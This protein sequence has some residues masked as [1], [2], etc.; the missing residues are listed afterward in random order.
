VESQD[1]QDQFLGRNSAILCVPVCACVCVEGMEGLQLPSA[2]A[3]CFG[4]GCFSDVVLCDRCE[5][6]ASRRRDNIVTVIGLE[7]KTRV[8]RL[9]FGPG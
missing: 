8:C 3:R 4:L 7:S 9:A 2:L 5:L 6:K 1:C